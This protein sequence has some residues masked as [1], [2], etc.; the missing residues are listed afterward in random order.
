MM[1]N[2]F[3]GRGRAQSAMKLTAALR[4]KGI[5]ITPNGEIAVRYGVDVFDGG[6]RVSARGWVTGNSDFGKVST[7]RLRLSDG[8]QLEV[9]VEDGD[10]EGAS[11]EVT[12]PDALAA[13]SSS[14]LAVRTR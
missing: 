7:A 6:A 5:L 3:N 4:G 9:T 14:P 11:V 13:A 12:N 1:T 2:S 10:I 8:V